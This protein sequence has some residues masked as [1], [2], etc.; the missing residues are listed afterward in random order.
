MNRKS[1]YNIRI[2]FEKSH[3][4]FIFDKNSNKDILDFFG[5]YA[6]LSL[7]YSHP[8]YENKAFHD[9]IKRISHQK[10]VNNEIASD[11]AISFDKEFKSFTSMDKFHYYHYAC[12]G[13]LAIEAAIKTALDYKNNKYKKIISFKGSFH[14]INGYGGLVTDRFEPVNQR[15]DGFLG[16]NW[17]RY[18][19]PTVLTS[20]RNGNQN[21]IKKVHEVLREIKNDIISEGDI[22]GILIEPIQCTYGDHYFT[23]DFF[24]GIRE[25]ATEHDI[26]L[27]FDEV[28][29]GFGATGKTWYFENLNIVPDILVF[30]KKTQLSGIMV[31]KNFGNIFNKPIRLE[32]TWDADL[33]DMVRCKYVIKAYK[34]YKILQN[35]IDR[36]NQLIKGLKKIENIQN[37][38]NAGLLVAFDFQNNSLRD[39]F[40]DELFKNNMIVNP[41]KDKSIRLRPPLSV[42]TNEIDTAID[43]LEQASKLIM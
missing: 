30:G 37:I 16:S 12:T 17:K 25:I 24:E 22:G 38:R 18:Y 33:I 13:A 42:N 40:V 43:R 28:Q 4:S 21:T 3:N 1:R 36:S 7:G 15:L 39:K 32:V 27:I 19:N 14:G 31:N 29:T 34:E 11:E 5:Q 8:I 20:S 26:P 23:D 2:D 6:T 10:I 35:V 9:D 41:T